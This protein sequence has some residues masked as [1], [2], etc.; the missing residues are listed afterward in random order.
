MH[1]M[2]KLS[3]IN[4]SLEMEGLNTSNVEVKLIFFFIKQPPH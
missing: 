1:R 3:I 2:Q 4:Y